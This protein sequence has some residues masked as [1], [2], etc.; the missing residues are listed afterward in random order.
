MDKNTLYQ[1]IKKFNNQPSVAGVE[2]SAPV[3]KAYSYVETDKANDRAK[4]LKFLLEAGYMPEIKD[5][6]GLTV[7]DLA[8][9]SGNLTTHLVLENGIDFKKIIF[10]D[11]NNQVTNKKLVDFFEK[12]KIQ[13]LNNDFLEESEFT[14]AE[15]ADL[16]IFNP[17]IGGSSHGDAKFEKLNPI[18]SRLNFEDYLKKQDIDTTPLNISYP[19]TRKILIKSELTK[20]A[21]KQ[22]LKDIKIFNYKDIYLQSKQLEE[23]GTETNIVK[24]RATFDKVFSENGWLIFYAVVNPENFKTLFKDFKEVF[25]YWVDGTKTTGQH[26]IIAQKTAIEHEKCFEKSGDSFTEI[27]NCVKSTKSARNEG[28]LDILEGGIEQ[29]LTQL[30]ISTDEESFT[31]VSSEPEKNDNIMQ[32]KTPKEKPKT[33]FILRGD[34][35][36]DLSF[37]YKNILLK[38][39]PGTGK[40]RL[41]NECFIKKLGFTTATQ[42]NNILRINIHSASS[43]ADLM[44]GIGISSPDGQIRYDE[45][46]GLILYH[47]QQAIE[48]PYEP[49]VIVLEEIQENSLNELIGDLIYLIEDDKRVAIHTLID[50]DKLFE[51]GQSYESLDQFIEALIQ[52]KE[53][54][55]FVKIPYLVESKTLH[56]KL[57]VPANLYF[58]CT[59][60]YRDDKKI[61]EDNL[62]RRFDLIELYPDETVLSE[63]LVRPFLETLNKSILEHF[64]K[65][66]IHPDRF[67]IGHANWLKA[68]DKPSFCRAFLK[69]ITEFKDIREI[70]YSDIEP[71]LK[72]IKAIK[73]LPFQLEMTEILRGGDYK[74]IIDNLQKTAYSD[75]L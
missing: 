42:R 7:L 66:E 46:Q 37:P 63:P 41:I 74:T 24:F 2:G 16:I 62:L 3:H 39:V 38:G 20:T 15:K 28:D 45:K 35:F 34:K 61:I 71:V 58:F 67:L 73:E 33:P 19:T 4:F 51:I 44:Q 26:L 56:R 53:D 43:N 9:G 10:N 64:K 11:K 27:P 31:T 21:L 70:E 54:T 32:D 55:H 65:R 23:E 12:D 59:S 36:G 17:Q 47:L 22:I 68:T 50:K 60:N 29:L 1:Q 52:A 40:S 8:Y 30:N 57:I 13:I 14:E 48:R 5:K 49:F 75:I 72:D 18:V 6:K 69:A 25:D